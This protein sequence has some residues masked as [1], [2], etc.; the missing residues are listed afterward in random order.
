[1]ERRS[2]KTKKIIEALINI[3]VIKGIENITIKDIIVEADIN[4][5]TFYYHYTDKVFLLTEIV[6][7]T[8]SGLV[9]DIEIP[10]QI[11]T[12]S[13]VIYPP[14]LTLFNRVEKHRLVYK[15]LLSKNGLP[16]IRWKMIE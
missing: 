4:R 2:M 10:N 7:E 11:H 12:F 1:M 6:D 8:L 16:D 9:N 13:D 3:A 15:I 5:A 14:I